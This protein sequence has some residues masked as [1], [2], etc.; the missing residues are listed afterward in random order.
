M[1]LYIYKV[2]LFISMGGKGY[3]DYLLYTWNY[4]QNSTEQNE[5]SLT[6][7]GITPKPHGVIGVNKL[8]CLIKYR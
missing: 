8:I 5:Y 4:R 6:F 1:A 3:P 2:P 7:I